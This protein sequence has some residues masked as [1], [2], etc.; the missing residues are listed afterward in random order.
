MDKNDRDYSNDEITVHWRAD[1][2]VHA[3]I[4]YTRLRSVF[5]PSRRPWI[6]IDKGTTNEIIDIVDQCPTDALTY[7]R[8][9]DP[10]KAKEKEK[11]SDPI[12]ESRE[13][14]ESLPKIQIVENGPALVSGDF[15]IKDIN[16]VKLAKAN[17]IALCRCGKSSSLPFCDG[18][19][20][21]IGFKENR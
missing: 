5:D 1:K 9:A 2:C 20:N 6:R 7:T 17:S 12:I 3:T 21:T 11:T 16:G 13:S 8:I 15:E 14:K 10:K 19:H 18:T 4:C